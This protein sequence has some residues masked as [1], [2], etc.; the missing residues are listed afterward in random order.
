MDSNDA[1]DTSSAFLTNSPTTTNTEECSVKYSLMP[2]QYFYP[3]EEDLKES[4]NDTK[5]PP[6]APPP[7]HLRDALVKEEEEN[8]V[9][10]VEKTPK[11]RKNKR[12]IIRPDPKYKGW[13]FC[14]KFLKS[15]EFVFFFFFRPTHQ[16]SLQLRGHDYD[17]DTKQLRRKI[18]ASQNLRIHHGQVSLLPPIKV[19]KGLA[20]FHSAQPELERLLHQVSR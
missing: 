15:I 12:E 19:Q 18:K 7:S 8:S 11:R 4:K 10:N 5:L 20:K 13:F 1:L 6:L 17:G 2:N 3:Y 14:F 9:D 16:T